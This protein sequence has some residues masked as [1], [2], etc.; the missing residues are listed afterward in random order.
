MA[1][2]PNKVANMKHHLTLLALAGLLMTPS[3]FAGK[4]AVETPE[5]APVSAESNDSAVQDLCRTY[6]E[7][8][9]I[10]SNKRPAYIQECVANMTGLSDGIQ[11]EPLP[12]LS[13]GSEEAVASP[14]SE[15]VNDDPEQLVRSEL[16]ETPD[17][18]AEQLDARKN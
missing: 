18:A 3:A 6:A 2:H 8:D 13:E 15:Q 12:L 16:V 17:P 4:D 1:T 11:S 10:A 14:T 7:E 9:G 5:M